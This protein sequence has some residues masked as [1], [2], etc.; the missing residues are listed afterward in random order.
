MDLVFR[1]AGDRVAIC[2][3]ATVRG[4]MGFEVSAY[5]SIIKVL[6]D[7]SLFPF[8]LSLEICGSPLLQQCHWP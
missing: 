5:R 2:D 4:V 8:S 1:P 3:G 7:F 6:G